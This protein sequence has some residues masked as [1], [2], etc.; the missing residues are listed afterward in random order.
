M[1]FQINNVGGY[2]AQ[3]GGNPL[4]NSSLI[5]AGTPRIPGGSLQDMSQ[6]QAVIQ[7]PVKFIENVWGQDVKVDPRKRN[8]DVEMSF[9]P[10]FGRDRMNVGAFP[11]AGAPR[12]R[13][14]VHERMIPEST[15]LTYSRAC[16]NECVNAAGPNYLRYWQIWDYAPFLPT[17]GNIALDPRYGMDTKRF[18]QPYRV[19]KGNTP[20][21]K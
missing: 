14:K 1:S 4:N 15:K 9:W 7:K 2:V 3:N 11:Y 20:V 8:F 6:V 18:T 16:F 19:S 12:M 17:N 13:K 21:P 5:A 10:K